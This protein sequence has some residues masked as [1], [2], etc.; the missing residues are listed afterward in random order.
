MRGASIAL[1]DSDGVRANLTAGWLAPMSHEVYMADGL[2][3]T[4]FNALAATSCWRARSS[5]RLA[6]PLIDRHRRPYEGTD[7]QSEAI[8]ANLDRELRV[9]EQ[10]G[11]DATHAF[12]VV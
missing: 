9:V 5:T 3:A 4:D 11:R 8:Q 1:P 2:H 12:V 7:N 6:A 10:L